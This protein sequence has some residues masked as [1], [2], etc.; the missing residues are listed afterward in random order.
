ME[1]EV[2]D[3]EFESYS[4]VLHFLILVNNYLQLS[5]V[6]LLFPLISIS[7]TTFGYYLASEEFSKRC[8]SA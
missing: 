1:K 8:S 2:G 6:K 3:H 7:S 4:G 5:K